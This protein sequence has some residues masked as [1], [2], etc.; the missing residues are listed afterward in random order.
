MTK[1]FP[2]LLSNTA[3]RLFFRLY[4]LKQAPLFIQT[5]DEEHRADYY[6]LVD[7]FEEASDKYELKPVKGG[8][9]DWLILLF[10]L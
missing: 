2:I 4:L 6:K 8:A 10:N 9:A 1:D 3:F 7:D 5:Q